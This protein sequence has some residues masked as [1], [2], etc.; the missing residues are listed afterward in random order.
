[1]GH[2]DL[3]RRLG[4][5][6]IQLLAI[7]GA[8]GTCRHCNTILF[9]KEM[10]IN[11]RLSFLALF[12]QMGATLPKGGPAGLFLGFLIYGTVMLCV[13]QCFGILDP[14]FPS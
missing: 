6:E 8:I 1:M 9:S 11:T 10:Y 3:H 12:V 14:V 4:A 13:N 2:Q 7:G 5:K